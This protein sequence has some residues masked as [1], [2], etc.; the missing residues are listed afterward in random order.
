MSTT[1]TIAGLQRAL[2]VAEQIQDLEA[3]LARVMAASA[4]VASVPKATS[5]PA[6]KK[7]RRS[8]SPEAC[9][10]IAAA[11]KARW[12]KAKSNGKGQPWYAK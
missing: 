1:P 10:K 9:A 3:E 2:A 11:A 8:M 12:A 7:G 6:V 5:T 4:P